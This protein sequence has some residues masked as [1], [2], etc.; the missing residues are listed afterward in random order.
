MEE[1]MITA[2]RSVI[3]KLF[4]VGLI[5]LALMQVPERTTFAASDVV[6]D[7]QLTSGYEVV[8]EGTGL[9]RIG[10]TGEPEAEYDFIFLEYLE[11]LHLY[12]PQTEETDG[13]KL[14]EF[15]FQAF[16]RWGLRG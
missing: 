16:M 3:R 14:F 15:H 1:T 10:I 13:Q 4:A 7:I 2:G 11:K 5:G 8:Q 12:I 9:G 6:D